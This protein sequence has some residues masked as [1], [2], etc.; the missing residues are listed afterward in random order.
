MRYKAIS[1]VFVFALLTSVVLSGLA[2]ADDTGTPFGYDR[3]TLRY[4]QGRYGQSM[5]RML[6][7]VRAHGLSRSDQRSL[8]AVR[9]ALLPTVEQVPAPLRGSASDEPF[10][11]FAVPGTPDIY[12]SVASLLF[13]DD[14]CKAYAWLHANGGST[15][16]LANYLAMIK[17]HDPQ[18]FP[19]GHYPAP[20][21]ALAIPRDAFNEDDGADTD[22]ETMALNFFNEARAFII[23]HELAHIRFGHGRT[24]VS[25][26]K[27]RDQERQA[28]AFA[29]DALAQ[30]GVIPMGAYL[31]FFSWSNYL[32]TRWDF[33]TDQDWQ[34]WQAEKLTHPLTP[35]RMQALADGLLKR[36]SSYPAVD[37][38]NVSGLAELMAQL[39]AFTADEEFQQS[40]RI[41]GAAEVMV[42][43]RSLQSCC[44][45]QGYRTPTTQPFT[46]LYIGDYVHYTVDGPETMS[47]RTEFR[48]SGDRVNGTFDFG[49]GPGTLI[50]I[51]DGVNLYFSWRW[52]WTYGQGIMDMSNDGARFT[53]A[54]GYRDSVSNG[55]TWSGRK[56]P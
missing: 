12:M 53:G 40:V 6:D 21:D 44:G 11:F 4:W 36:I 47:V 49:L 3:Q 41:I 33:P 24:P 30:A 27:R 26:A 28:D 22:V 46:G 37:R 13:L 16:P 39:A 10:T 31:L 43:L 19:G 38:T 51:V 54:W 9:I 45:Q 1:L 25:L 56:Q 34:N 55:G 15:E 35:E 32:D 7:A 5:P 50:G 18:D 52:A 2:Y 8:R 42:M 17:Y 29:L 23:A 20:L 48:R 14:L